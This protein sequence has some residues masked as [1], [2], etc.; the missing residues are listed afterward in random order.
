MSDLT[1]FLTGTGLIISL[2]VFVI[3]LIARLVWYFNNLDWK[4]ERIAYKPHMAQG[5]KGGLYSMFRWLLP[6][7]T[8]AW[9]RQPFV[10]FAF[11]L[12]HIG[13]ILVPLFLIGHAEV[14]QMA[15]GFSLPSFPQIVADVLTVA[16]IIGAVFIL[17]RRLALPE[18]R[19]IT[20]PTDYLILALAVVPFVTGFA[21]R[22]HVGGYET[23]MLVH[24]ISGHCF[25]LLAPFTKLSHIAMYFATRWQIGADFAIKRGGFSRGAFFPW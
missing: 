17:A 19:F 4:L 22:M 14:L 11:F 5:M 24:L 1:A 15:L 3:G 25:L 13:A 20:K 8:Y 12:F 21:A 6:Y 16:T 10:A 18:V 7:G 9:R 2:A 23:W